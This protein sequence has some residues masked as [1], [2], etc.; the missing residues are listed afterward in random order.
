MILPRISVRKLHAIP[1]WCIR[2]RCRWLDLPQKRAW[3]AKT[4]IFEAGPGHFRVQ[5]DDHWPL[6]GALR[7]VGA[8]LPGPSNSVGIRLLLWGSRAWF[9]FWSPPS[10]E[11]VPLCRG[12]LP[13][14]SGQPRGQRLG[15][16]SP[17][18]PVRPRCVCEGAT[19]RS[20]AVF[21]SACIKSPA[22]APHLETTSAQHR[23]ATAPGPAPQVL[24]FWCPN[25]LYP[26]DLIHV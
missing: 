15:F 26:A 23:Q 4:R 24:P 6:L 8:C 13:G 7:A 22:P 17:C 25:R 14:P 10:F 5:L 3:V 1:H 21:A 19:L 20:A 11:G 18:L 2:D 16:M 12:A 9:G